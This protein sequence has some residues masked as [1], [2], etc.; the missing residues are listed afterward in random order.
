MRT[1]RLFHALILVTFA[2]GVVTQALQTQPPQAQQPPPTQQP[3]TIRT[4]IVGIG[5]PPK[6]A[7]PEFIPLS[8]E[9]D[10][11]NAAKTIADVLWEDFAFE[12]EF[13]LIARD[14]LRT[15][16]RPA[17]PDEWAIE[18]WKEVGA[19]GVVIGS[20][21]RTADGI[22]VE[23]RLMNVANGVMSL[24]KQY[25]GSL[26]SL[27]DGGRIFA[28][29]IADEI[30]KQQ[31]NL[32]GVA[33][34]KLA[35]SSDR[36]GAR[37]KGP[38]AERDIS[39]IYRADYD[40]ANQSRMTVTRS[41][42]IAPVWAPDGN[43]IAYTSYRS[44][45]PDIIVQLVNGLGEP[46]RP[47]RGT[48]E[49]HNFLAVWSPDGSKLAFSSNR[50]GGGNSEIYIVNRDGTGL[51]RITNHPMADTTPTWAPTGAQ[52][53]FTSDRSGSPQVYVVNVDGT[54]LR[55][56]SEESY[57]DRATWSPAPFNEIAYTSRT[58]G[59]YEIRIFDFATRSSRPITDGIGS[60][61]QPAFA[62]NGRH[63]A[64]TSD[65]TG[66][67]QVYTIARDGTGLR[68]ITRLGSN[69]YPNWSQ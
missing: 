26:R 35:F 52:L 68:Q 13:Y 2:L 63:L 54:D 65:R 28:H 59:G 50:D 8:K 11:L 6:L 16:P 47:A 58:G 27:S 41:L 44:G 25:T 34:T 60:N 10:V 30:H 66:Q 15:V 37:M 17:S 24:G 18:R 61:E 45:Y 22:V 69:R 3:D 43:M 67:A 53:A 51:R 19:D 4:A 7:V 32:R 55:R 31:R 38:T 21:R 48:A 14:T 40:G 62:P 49:A 57:C 23:A 39:N 9:P 42:D 1:N 29:S 33:R 20:V 5:G 46:T 56:I 12:K 64:F 36:D